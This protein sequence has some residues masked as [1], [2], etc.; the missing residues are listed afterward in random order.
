MPE[1][2]VYYA[3]N[4][5]HIGRDRW[6]PSSYGTDFSSDGMENL[7]FGKVTVSADAQ[8][9]SRFLKKDVGFGSGDGEGLGGYLSKQAKSSRSTKIRAFPEKLDPSFS[10]VNQPA[11]AT[12]GSESTFADLQQIMRKSSDVLIYIHGFNVAWNE[13]VGSA[14]A[15]QEMLNRPTPDAGGAQKTT[16]VLFTWPS[17]G[18][19]LPF[20]SYK[21]DRSDARG[22][23]YA[24]GRGILKLRDFLVRLK[25]DEDRCD[26]CLHLLCHSMGNYVLQN[27]LARIIQ[28]IP[29]SSLPRLFEHVFLCSPDVDEDAL[30]LGEPL[31]RL[32]EITRNVSVYFNTGDA[33][34]H[35]SDVTKGNP[36]RLG[37]SGASRPAM[38]HSKIHQ[39]DCS[40]VVGGL[41]EHGY[42]LAGNANRDIR[43]S[44][45]GRAQDFSERDRERDP[46]ARNT[47][48][49]R[50]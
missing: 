29:A 50:G 41:V 38:L 48:T 28:F 26:G 12:Y 31:G 35:V 4:R 34:L 49:L 42:Y 37:T 44:L 22:S 13:A 1:L 8:R 19:A 30:E 27:A 47:W 3:T 16:V 20:V 17:N 33:A 6:K 23:G 25:N 7:R 39:I 18:Q 46:I 36:D 9:I 40:E 15:L 24:I 43:L 11:G 32:H 14:L 2:Q 5:R 10:D 21:S 45:G